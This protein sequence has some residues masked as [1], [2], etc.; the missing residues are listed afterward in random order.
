[1]SKLH[2][3]VLKAYG[4]AVLLTDKPDYTD[5]KPYT[6]DEITQQIKDLIV[7]IAETHASDDQNINLASFIGE[8]N[9]L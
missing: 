7:Q 2:E 4:S 6:A 5:I 9:S 8:V 1:M 3:I